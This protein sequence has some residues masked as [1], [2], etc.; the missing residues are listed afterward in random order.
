MRS[1]RHALAVRIA[2]AVLLLSLLIGL[3][4]I[5]ALRGLLYRQMD[6]TLLHLAEVEAQAGAAAAGSDFEFHEGVLLATRAGPTADLTRF[7]QLWTSDGHPLVRSRN[8]ATNLDL[9]ASSLAAAEKGEV[10]WN[11]HTWHG[12]R[13][14]CVLY[15]LRLVGSSHAI[16]VLQ[17]AAPLEPI[18]RIIRQFAFLVAVGAL[19]ASIGGYA[20]GWFLAGAALRPTRE[21]TDQ[22]EALE[23][24][25]LSA[26]IT[27]H[28]EVD[29]FSRLVTVLNGML[30]RL[31]SAFQV[32]RRFTADA[33]HELRAPL[34]ALRGE[35]DIALRR[36][37]SAEEYQ[38]TLERAR[39]EV[40][41]LVRLTDDL[42]TLARS[43][44]ALPLE[45]VEIVEIAAVVER[46][47][48]RYAP[49]ATEAGVRFEPTG[50]EASV[51]G[52]PGILERVL[53]NLVDN[54]IKYSPRGGAVH[55]GVVRAE[56][57]AITVRDEGPG[58]PAGD[59]PHLFT[60]FFRGD[61][62][63]PRADGT[64][65]GLAIARAG[66]EAHGGNLEFAGNA[67]G[68]TFRL[69]LPLPHPITYVRSEAATGGQ[70]SQPPGVAS[71]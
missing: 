37:R 17:V 9:P 63:R 32:Q 43:D 25:S 66:A 56:E 8:L 52:D 53:A 23:V 70:P 2:P 58:I 44:A 69:T 36:T 4:S 27:A 28:A 12:Q 33:S 64:G 31:D 59:G 24:G 41:R 62:A 26:R 10:S 1:F 71:S 55:I 6:A 29:E 39:E 46:V 51:A 19:V 47:L 35:I 50:V 20:L 14:R 11:T 61:H 48:V 13:L 45:H 22:A 67:P 34:T 42:L 40:L 3:F 21:I 49:I 7:A 65:L 18:Q 15:P 16:H 60:R 54:A 5:A 30:A 38:L 68:A 57:V